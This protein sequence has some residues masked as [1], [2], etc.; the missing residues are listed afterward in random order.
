MAR[1]IKGCMNEG[2]IA[3]KKKLN[4]SATDDFCPKCGNPLSFV[5]KDCRMELDGSCSICERCAARRKDKREQL[6]K[7][8]A[9]KMAKGAKAVGKGAVSAGKKAANVAESIAI[10]VKEGIDSRRKG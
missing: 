3:H 4:Y 1:A 5:C 6:G 2:C 10:D 7:E 8:V 9:A